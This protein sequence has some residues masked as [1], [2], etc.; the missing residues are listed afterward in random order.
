VR[1]LLVT[2][3]FPLDDADSRNA[4]VFVAD[5]ARLLADRGHR[6][7]VISPQRSDVSGRFEVR[8]FPR[9]GREPSLSHLDPRRPLDLVKLASVVLGGAAAVPRTARRERADHVV[10]MWAVPSGLLALLARM[11][12]RTPYSVWAL[13]SDIWRIRDYP[14][15]RRLLRS[16]L[17]GATNVYA[18]G[19]QLAA[20]TA[21][22]S[23]RPVPFLA[24]SRR[25]PPPGPPIW[26]DGRR[27]VVA[28]ARFHEHKGVDVLVE[29]VARLGDDARRGTVVHL[30]GEGPMRDALVRR[31]AGLGLGDVVRFEG[32]AGEQ[33]VSDA[34]ASAAVAVIPS[35]V[36]S[37]PLVL[38]DI[39][40]AGTDLVVTDAGDMGDLV[41]EHSAGLVARRGDAASLAEQLGTALLTGTAGTAD[42]RRRLAE[43]LS[44][45]GS[46]TRL[47][48]DL[49]GDG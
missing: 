30:F 42:G 18:D 22:I 20:D 13:G 34:L 11:L 24:T 41:R 6:V 9:L 33:V 48:L 45:D 44:L 31:V 19:V 23:G 35:R 7:T 5:T 43:H 29:A 36:E 27:H 40:Q 21:A 49:A 32:L 38:S 15:G 8:S 3:S 47:L 26:Q 2:S 37:I 17:R 1:I 4:G 25:L 14:G 46:V 39:C 16:V 12:T 28:I 10:A